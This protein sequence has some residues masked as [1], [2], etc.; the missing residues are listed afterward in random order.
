MSVPPLSTSARTD[1]SSDGSFAHGRDGDERL[2]RFVEAAHHVLEA[3]PMRPQHL[4]GLAAICLLACSGKLPD[5]EIWNEPA[6]LPAGD[7]A[8]SASASTSTTPPV[9]TPPSRPTAACDV[10]FQKDVLSVM[11][12]CAGTACHGDNSDEPFISTD[13]AART[14]ESLANFEIRGDRLVDTQSKD[15]DDSKLLCNLRGEKQCGAKMPLGGTLG[16]DQ[17]DT[18]T[19]WLACGAP[20]N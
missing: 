18:I 5:R 4:L 3:A 17:I 20:R 14:Y 11:K 19:K 15:P 10:S 8:P 2:E 16:E 6:T 13:D 12:S 7:P 9:V 1:A